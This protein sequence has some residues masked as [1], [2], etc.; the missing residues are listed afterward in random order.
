[1]LQICSGNNKR[2][3][4]GVSVIEILIAAA[5]LGIALV[6]LAGLINFS[7]R[8]SS[9]IN[10]STQANALL[11]ETMEA[12]RNFRD[13]TDWASNGLGTLAQGSD[14]Y[15]RKTI[16]GDQFWELSLGQETAGNF[17]RKVVFYQVYRDENDNIGEIGNEDPDTIK[18]V[19][20]VSWPEKEKIN[21]LEVSTYFTNWKK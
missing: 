9:L 13:N 19:A 15:P 20:T 14:Y 3:Q 10:R 17:T 4:K 7:L 8:I 18:A 12:V 16:G 11:Q 2:E 1:M 6:S 21:N 5:V